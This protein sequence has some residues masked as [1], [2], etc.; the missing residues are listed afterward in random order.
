MLVLSLTKKPEEKIEGQPL[1]WHP[2]MKWLDNSRLGD[3]E[4]SGIR[5]K[6]MLLEIIADINQYLPDDWRMNSGSTKKGFDQR[7]DNDF[8]IELCIEKENP[9]N[10]CKKTLIRSSLIGH[11]FRIGDAEILHICDTVLAQ[12]MTNRDAIERMKREHGTKFESPIS[13]NDIEKNPELIIANMY[14]FYPCPDDSPSPL[15][16]NMKR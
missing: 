1:D 4:S 15:R 11:S 12:W 10:L 8:R 16:A 6:K 14:Y 9:S 13:G 3:N 5:T 7:L 2:I